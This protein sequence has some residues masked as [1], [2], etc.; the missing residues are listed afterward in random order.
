V[1]AAA[2]AGA[3]GAKYKDPK[4]PLN[5]RID[6]RPAAAFPL[7]LVSSALWQW[8]PLQGNLVDDDAAGA[9]CPFNL[10]VVLSQA[11]VAPLLLLLC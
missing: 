5:K 6:V 11:L 2:G 9:Q 1:A 7:L 4:Q 3:G 8:R 10:A